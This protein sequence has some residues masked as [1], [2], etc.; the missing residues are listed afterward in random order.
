MGETE[1]AG[2]RGICAS[3]LPEMLLH[4]EFSLVGFPCLAEAMGI[5]AR[6]EECRALPSY[7]IGGCLTAAA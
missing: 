4:P 6:L 2:K 3:F 1:N 5:K 7:K